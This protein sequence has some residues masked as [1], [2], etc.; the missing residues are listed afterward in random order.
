MK[1]AGDANCDNAV[2]MSDV[3]LIMQSLANPNK[4]AI[5]GSDKNALTAQG[6]A[7]G[8]YV[9]QKELFKLSHLYILY[10]LT[11]SPDSSPNTESISFPPF[12]MIVRLLPSFISRQTIHMKLMK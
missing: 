10:R 2:D 12:A 4:F 3:V 5:G 11:I 6:N 7:N 9:E 8:P 1:L